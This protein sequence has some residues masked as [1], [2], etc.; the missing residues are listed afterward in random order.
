[1][2]IRS[3]VRGAAVEVFIIVVGIGLALSADA[4]WDDLQQDKRVRQHLTSLVRDFEQMSARAD[5]SLTT[6]TTAVAAGKKLQAAFN[7]GGPPLEPDSALAWVSRLLTYEV[8]SPGVGGYEALVASGDLEHLGNQ[9]LKRNLGEF[10]GSFEDMRVS[11]RFLLE[12]QAQLIREEVFARYVGVERILGPFVE[13][14]PSLRGAPVDMWGSSPILVNG[15]ASL[16]MCQRGVLEDYRYL[17]VR[18]DEI[19]TLLGR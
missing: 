7:P 12:A 3:G 1:M 14:F 2:K 11:E 19:H 16:T 10:F 18:L 8:F 9:E 5:S 13:G 15:L 6:A 17:R 4:W